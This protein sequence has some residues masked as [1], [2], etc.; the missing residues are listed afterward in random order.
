MCSLHHYCSSYDQDRRDFLNH[1]SFSYLFHCYIHLTTFSV[2]HM[3]LFCFFCSQV[4]FFITHYLCLLRWIAMYLWKDCL[5]QST[6]TR[7]RNLFYLMF[8][9][10]LCMPKLKLHKLF[11]TNYNYNLCSIISQPAVQQACRRLQVAQVT[12]LTDY[13][14]TALARHQNGVSGYNTC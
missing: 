14:H 8:Q 9:D 13:S 2:V 3:L 4:T 7:S 11:S 1:S 6:H 12:Q 5:G 10:N